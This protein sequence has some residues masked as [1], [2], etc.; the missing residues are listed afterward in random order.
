M[1]NFLLQRIL[2]NTYTKS[3]F[4]RSISAVQE[5]LEHAFYNTDD[6]DDSNHTERIVKH[7]HASGDVA[8]AERIEGWGDPV[9]SVFTRENLYEKLKELKG[10][11]ESLPELALYVPV[12]FGHRE[13]EHIGRWCREHIDRKVV[14]SLSVEP[15][16]VGGC[17]FVWKGT[18]HDFS[19]QYFIQKK[20]GE[21]ARLISAYNA[22]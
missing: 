15:E 13:I 19:L 16:V 10:E 2:S 9:L 5:F 17:A 18:Y 7:A 14:L 3:D 4:Y 21:I 1:D 20:E 8:V 6:N 12:A 11:V 22:A